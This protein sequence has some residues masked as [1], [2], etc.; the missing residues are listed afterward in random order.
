MGV[1]NL[2]TVLAIIPILRLATK[3]A[4]TAACTRLV[5]HVSV[6]VDGKDDAVIEVNKQ[7]ISLENH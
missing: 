3:C 5:I 2:K 1:T 7:P 4:T 6:V